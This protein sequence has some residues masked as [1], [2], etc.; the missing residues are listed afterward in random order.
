[1]AEKTEKWLK[2]RALKLYKCKV[3]IELCH[4]D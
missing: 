3:E 1:M 2:I 4:L